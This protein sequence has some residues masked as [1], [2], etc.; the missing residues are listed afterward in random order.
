MPKNAMMNLAKIA[1]VIALS[2]C[3]S[4]WARNPRGLAVPRVTTTLWKLPSYTDL[5]G[6]TFVSGASGTSNGQ[7]GISPVNLTV[8]TMVMLSQNKNPAT[9]GATPPG[10]FLPNTW[11][12]GAQTG[13]TPV[14]AGGQAQLS[15]AAT[16]TS[17][18]STMQWEGGTMGALMLG[19]DLS[20]SN[21]RPQFTPQINFTNVVGSGPVL[22][23]GPTTT[24]TTTMTIQC[25]TFVG[26][27]APQNTTNSPYIHVNLSLVGPGLV[28]G[29]AWEIIID[30]PITEGSG[31][32]A[33]ISK[34]YVAQGSA[35]AYLF[36]APVNA[37][38]AAPYITFNSGSY[39]NGTFSQQTVSY[40]VTYAQFQ[41][42]LNYMAAQGWGVNPPFPSGT[43]PSQFT[44]FQTHVNAEMPNISTISLG[45]SMSAW[46]GTVIL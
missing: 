10:F 16:G 21:N 43:T 20:T 9:S 13:F 4:A 45:W 12:A 18:S 36:L 22:F 44:L 3:G 25:P 38:S 33:N 31:Q 46:T 6:N 2:I 26:S 17:P 42:M 7:T 37:A 30:I 32:P 11:N 19:S 5:Y 8:G 23:T 27:G 34:S 39:F 40:T 1:L 24:F 41:N 35:N 14:N 15:V 29:Q 28:S